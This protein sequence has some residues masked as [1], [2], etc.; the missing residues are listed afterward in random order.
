M[1]LPNILKDF[2][3]YNAWA[4]EQI[5]NWLFSKPLDLLDRETSSS[6]PTLRLTLMHIWGAQEIWMQRLKGQETP[7]FPSENFQGSLQDLKTGLM[8]NSQSFADFTEQSPEP[9]FQAAISYQNSRGEKFHTPNSEV[10]L[11]CLQHSTYHR[12]QIVTMARGLGLTDPPP[13]DYIFYVRIRK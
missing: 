5:L 7:I 3:R 4:N 13:T 10:L 8:A 2:A 9:F 12:G 11:H 1:T 6:F